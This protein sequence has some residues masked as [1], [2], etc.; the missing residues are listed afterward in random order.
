MLS[1]PTTLRRSHSSAIPGLSKPQR[2]PCQP[3]VPRQ[4]RRGRNTSTDLAVW[5]GLRQNWKQ[6]RE[7][8][9]WPKERENVK[10]KTASAQKQQLQRIWRPAS[11][12]LGEA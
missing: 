8:G 6:G 5:G 11:S 4:V 9:V 12:T 10:V 3:R 1:P 2:E 7:N